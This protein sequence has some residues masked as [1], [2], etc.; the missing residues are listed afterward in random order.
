MHTDIT[1]RQGIEASAPA[2][3]AQRA[4][5][6]GERIRQAELGAAV[7]VALTTT[8]PLRVQLQRCA[9]AVVEHLEASFA[10][11][12]TLNEREEMLE[13]QASAGM[14]THLDG[15]H[16][17]V[18]LG[19]LK[20]GRIAQLRTPHLTNAVADDPQVSDQAWAAR[21]RMVAFAGYPLLVGDRTVGVLALF[22]R[23]ALTVS[24]IAALGAVAN[25]LGLAIARAWADAEAMAERSRLEALSR[26]LA[27]ER[28]LLQQVLDVLPEGVAIADAQAHLVL[29]NTVAREILGADVYAGAPAVDE[30]TATVRYHTRH[31][32]GT[33]FG[34]QDGL[35]HRSVFGGEVVQG[36][37]LLVR[38]G[39]D[40]REVPLL[41]NS[42]P[43]RDEA[44]TIAGAVMVFQDISAIKDLE[45]HKDE[46]LATVSHDLKN[47][48]TAIL[49][50]AQLLARRAGRVEGSDGARLVEGL[51]SIGQTAAAMAGQITELLDTTRLHM[52]GT[53]DL[54]LTPVELVALLGRLAAAL[55]E[56]SERHVV[57]LETDIAALTCVCDERRL[58]RALANLVANAIKYSPDGGPVTIG[59]ALQ[60]EGS[61]RW[62]V[63]TVADRGVGIPIEDLPRVFERFYRAGN[64]GTIQGTGIGLAGAR[65]IIEQ[66][67][68]AI[69]IASEPGEGTTVTVRLP[70]TGPAMG[71]AQ[72]R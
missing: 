25:T 24:T 27:A 39:G 12:W 49:G 70:V 41:A 59:L 11:V 38:R 35:L 53:L 50:L 43:L 29:T 28:D 40:G 6:L 34:P 4:T 66:H 23:R 7:G 57:E 44:G 67:A 32:D 45:R 8:A 18:P 46:F 26:Q 37:Q 15:P 10:R 61:E 2:E 33:P 51:M 21:E 20:I 31:A 60:N 14:Y 63:I 71:D 1:D 58:E 5:E 56:G 19:A 72:A 30:W 55:G 47:P 62:A 16:A 9:E 64:V 42:A 54:D 36:A 17:R 48:L 65:Q 69:A 3:P 22:A 68:G 52:D 13:L